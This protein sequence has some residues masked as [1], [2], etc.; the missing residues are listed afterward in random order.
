MKVASF[1]QLFV[2]AY[3]YNCIGANVIE[4]KLTSICSSKVTLSYSIFDSKTAESCE[5]RCWNCTAKYRELGSSDGGL[6]KVEYSHLNADGEIRL[7]GLS[8]ESNYSIHLKCGAIQSNE[9][10][11]F[12]EGTNTSC[13]DDIIPSSTLSPVMVFHEDTL[14][15]TRDSVLG[16]VFSLLGL[17][18]ILITTFYVVRKI[19]RR[20]R[21]ER[22]RTYLG[23][24]IIDPFENLQNR[25]EEDSGSQRL[26]EA[27]ENRGSTAEL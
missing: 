15:G 24:T 25:I 27:R 22:I 18:I 7:D 13:P 3:S 26:I 8:A 17:L 16:I 1:I 20:R 10:F 19:R 2:F 23:S 9:V 12:T 21:L 6:R 4:V 11:F 5:Y 14:L